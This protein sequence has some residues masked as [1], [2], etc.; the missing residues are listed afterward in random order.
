MD[1]ST[2]RKCANPSC[3]RAIHKS[4]RYCEPCRKA[5][6]KAPNGNGYTATAAPQPSQAAQTGLAEGVTE[7][8]NER[9][10]VTRTDEAVRTLEDL[11]RVCKID[12]ET[13]EVVEWKAN[14][15]EMG[16]VARNE[17]T[18]DKAQALPLYQ[19]TAR[20]KRKSGLT[21]T[22]ERLRTEL[23]EDFRNITDARPFQTNRKNFVGGD[24]LF[25]FAP[26]DLHMG[27]LAWA[28]EG[29]SNYDISTAVD[30]FN[31][32]LD[33]LLHR[34][35]LLSEGKLARI[36]FVVGNDVCHI[37]SKKGQTTMGTQMDVDTRYIKIVRRIFET[38]RRAVDVLRQVAPVD[39][40]VCPG[41]HDEVTSFYIGELLSVAFE[42]HPDVTVD[43]S[44]R[45]RKYYEFGVN[46]FGFTHGDA[47]SVNE[48]PLAMA[49]ENPEAWARCSSR[50]WHIGHLHKSEK[51]EA[52]SRRSVQDLFSDKGIRVRRL[53]SMSGHDA[54]HT[55]HAYM[56][57]R[58]CEAF[59]FHRTAGFTDQLNF[60]IDHFTGEPLIL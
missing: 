21:L 37:D 18:P 48:L 16:W 4:H 60:N 1:T 59:V 34:A 45:L 35:L 26:F 12:T 39:I 44:A 2:R 50:E 49:R 14:K 29:P 56:D 41:N 57:R 53:T 25:E 43:N 23:V 54:W 20:M 13:W 38:H 32:S 3:A 28:E 55:K 5:G 40:V 11:I 27:K 47:E 8:G 6:F 46:L 7:H 36:L 15:W 19:V 17:D 22:M 24:W 9:T 51:W 10:V 33:F 42:G 52:R 58:A 31:A 30:L